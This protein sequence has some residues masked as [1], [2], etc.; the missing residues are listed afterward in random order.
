MSLS[1]SPI[2]PISPS[3][4]SV[5]TNP[6]STAQYTE[7]I[8]LDEEFPPPEEEGAIH[9]K[10]AEGLPQKEKETIRA[11]ACYTMVDIDKPQSSK[12]EV[13]GG[14]CDYSFCINPVSTSHYTRMVMLDKFFI[15]PEDEGRMILKE[16][17]GLPQR[18][19]ETIR[20]APCYTMVDQPY[21]PQF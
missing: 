1:I 7:M 8:M 5:C 21:R 4:Y 15:P 6:V 9:L 19:K 16:A 12:E 14:H 2:P 3:D 20:A 17:V 13:V 10:E 18:E 11:A